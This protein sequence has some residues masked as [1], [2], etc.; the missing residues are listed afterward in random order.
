M[1]K[2]F[3]EAAA[4]AP[5]CVLI[6]N[7]D[8]ICYSR[9]AV[10]ASELQKRIVACL[11]TLMDGLDV[12]PSGGSGQTNAASSSTKGVFVIGT[13]SRIGDIDAAVRRAGR[14]DKEIEV[15][16]PSSADREAILL[17]LLTR[18]GVAIEPLHVSNSGTAY[19][20]TEASVREVAKLAQ[21]MVGSDLLSGVKEAVYLTL[22]ET[23]SLTR[24]LNPGKENKSQESTTHT[25]T[26]TVGASEI[27]VALLDPEDV[28]ISSLAGEFAGLDM[29]GEEEDDSEGSPTVVAEP[30]ANVNAVAATFTVA[31]ASASTP[32]TTASAPTSAVESANSSS[33]GPTGTSRVVTETALRLAGSKISPSALRE[34]V[35]EVP[36][37]RWTD[38]GGM[39]GVKQSLREVLNCER[40]YACLNYLLHRSALTLNFH[41]YFFFLNRWW[42]GPCCT[43][44]SSPR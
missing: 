19:D 31:V 25:P 12:Q 42:S 23:G 30:R 36:S 11:L 16:V 22:K 29:E 38:I 41:H 37:V 5:C 33:S 20:L 24:A 32:M 43:P 8:L 26:K 7:I 3:Q 9:T 35:I 44:S 18:A 13:T 21:G 10:G 4:K 40:I 28:V 27:G 6:D 17:Q 1:T 15:G 2:A 34:V 14:I 39:E